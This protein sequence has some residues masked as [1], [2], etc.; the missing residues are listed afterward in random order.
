MAADG[1]DEGRR[2]RAVI[3]Q[4][5]QKIQQSSVAAIGGIAFRT[6]AQ[7]PSNRP[8]LLRLELLIQIV[9]EPRQNLPTLHALYPFAMSLLIRGWT[10]NSRH[11]FLVPVAPISLPGAGRIPA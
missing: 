4:A 2:R 7:V 5:C 8:G 9:P 11:R 6:V 3:P 1:S 10:K